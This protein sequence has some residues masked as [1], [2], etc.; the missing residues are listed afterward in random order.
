MR[1][2]RLPISLRGF[3]RDDF[4]AGFVWWVAECQSL[5]STNLFRAHEYL[6]PA[7][8]KM[9]WV[10]SHL[11]RE[12]TSVRPWRWHLTILSPPRRQAAQGAEHSGGPVFRNDPG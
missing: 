7:S 1:A 9:A 6:Q 3:D 10:G 8:A 2:D 11:I 4:P 5:T 12:P